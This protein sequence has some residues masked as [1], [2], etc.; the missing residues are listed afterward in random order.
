LPGHKNWAA[1]ALLVV[2]CVASCAPSSD[3]QSAEKAPAAA[4]SN[5]VVQ[6]TPAK[7]APAEQVRKPSPI[8]EV[9]MDQEF[10]NA[11]NDSKECKD[12][13]VAGAAKKARHDF[14]V[15][16]S[17]AHADTP[18]MEEQWLWSVFA[19]TRN[20]AGDFRGAGTESSAALAVKAMCTEVWRSFT[21]S[22]SK[23]E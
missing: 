20:A 19:T 10:Q 12:I 9:D 16:L 17:F 2:L 3:K 1:L 18:E 22:R 15:H 7:Q 13:Q 21:P 23:A 8:I 14:R 6:S 4:D 5:P 11:F